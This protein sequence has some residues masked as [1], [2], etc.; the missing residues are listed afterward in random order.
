MGEGGRNEDVKDV[1]ADVGIGGEEND[2]AG[3]EEVEA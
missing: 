1:G 2:E 3:D